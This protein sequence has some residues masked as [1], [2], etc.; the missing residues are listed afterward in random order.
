MDSFTFDALFPLPWLIALILGLTVLTLG[1]YASRLARVSWPWHGLLIILR[2]GAL[3][4]ISLILLG[5]ARVASDTIIE[6]APVAVLVDR[7]RSMELADQ[8]GGATRQ[9][10]ADRLLTEQRKTLA[11]LAERYRFTAM[12][13]AQSVECIAPEQLWAPPERDRDFRSGT[14][15]GSALKQLLAEMKGRKNGAVLVIS[16][17][18]NNEAVD[19]V[20]HAAAFKGRTIPIYALALGRTTDALP[21]KECDVLV[22]SL[23]CPNQ[24]Q[25]RSQVPVEAEVTFIGCAQRPVTVVLSVDGQPVASK[26]HIPTHES[27]TTRIPFRF[28]ANIAGLHQVSVAALTLPEEQRQDNNLQIAMLR[29]EEFRTKV[30]Y[31]EG[32]LRWEYRYLRDFL[33]RF[34]LAETRCHLCLA[35]EP[36]PDAVIEL[37]TRDVLIIGDMPARR[38]SAAQMER[39]KAAVERG[40]GLIM[41]GGLANFG[42]GGYGGTTLGSLLPVEV[43]TTDLQID[44]PFWLKPLNTTATHIPWQLSDEPAQA[45]GIWGRLPRLDGRIAVTRLKPAA[46]PLLIAADQ[47]EQVLAPVDDRRVVLAGQTYGKGRA[48]AFTGDSLWKWAVG[49]L[50]ERNAYRRFWQQLIAWL[51]HWDEKGENSFALR[52]DK[53]LFLADDEVRI[54]AELRSPLGLPISDGNVE[55]TLTGPTG[56]VEPLATSAFAGAYR[57]TCVPRSR[58][59]YTIRGRAR[60]K[61]GTVLPE[62]SLPF[63][64][65]RPDL[66]R[67]ST[68]ANRALLERVATVSGGRLIRE[69]ELGPILTELLSHDRNTV[70]TKKHPPRPLWSTPWWLLTFCLLLTLE[71]LIRRYKRL[72]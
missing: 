9:Q 21:N 10:V 1:S 2:L 39:I 66:E 31:V 13:F 37:G 19:P 53:Y 47:T 14:R 51:G 7:S 45:A 38:F 42:P 32:R 15:L 34:P 68:V 44:S 59:T 61:E 50:E 11:Q 72:A 6:Q 41:L 56:R 30:I 54:E 5:P 64:V 69:N 22:G 24:I 43:Q 58:G 18:C 16:D 55:L 4:L 33:R 63:Q 12:E 8:P 70:L 62:E 25:I 23:T 3:A 36:V 35:D 60:T 65:L 48:L 49:P 40:A 71:W 52:L 27:E 57:A 46:F 17:G 29:V 20:A 28:P 26:T 67:D